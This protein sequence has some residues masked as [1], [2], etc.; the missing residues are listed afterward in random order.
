MNPV[1]SIFFL[2][3][4]MIY[5][6]VV[7]SQTVIITDDPEYEEGVSSA[8]LDLNSQQAGFLMPRMTESQREAIVAPAT[9]L[10]LFQTDGQA[11]FYYNAG[12]QNEPHWIVLGSNDGAANTTASGSW[13]WDI[14]GNRYPTVQIGSDVWMAE[15]LRVTKFRDGEPVFSM[16]SAS[17]W[18]GTDLAAYSIY[19][20]IDAHSGTFGLLYNGYAV[21]HPSGICPE[22]WMVPEESHWQSLADHLGG[23]EIAG[24]ALKAA[25]YWDVITSN[26]SNASGFSAL[27]SGYRSSGDG[28]FVSLRTIGGWWSLSAD[29]LSTAS[30]Y[31]L[32]ADSNSLTNLLVSANRGYAIRC[33]KESR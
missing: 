7:S 25:R 26:F 8:L 23:N 2:A 3:S 9:G 32:Q 31:M 16:Q 10:L 15:N 27:P 29:G 20:N 5:L 22:G 11:G 14:D 6:P 19:D 28:Y 33:V 30:V 24:Q 13:I 12:C 4:L 1:F 18:T 21:H 17:E